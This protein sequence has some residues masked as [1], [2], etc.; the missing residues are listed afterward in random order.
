MHRLRQ[1]FARHARGAFGRGP[2]FFGHGEIRLALLS[3]LGE[4]SAHGYELMTLLE[5]RCGA[6]YKASPGTIYPTLQQLDDEGL[7]RVESE[8]G[9]KIYAITEGGRAVVHDRAEQIAEIWRR[10]SSSRDWDVLHDPDAA[11]VLGPALRLAKVALKTVV[12]SHG[13]AETIDAIRAILE[14]ARLQIGRLR[15]RARR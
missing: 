10:A 3:L 12:K 5:Q 14:D 11:E 1:R 13:D 9:K 7:V 4:A 6:G 2:R 15:R 8:N